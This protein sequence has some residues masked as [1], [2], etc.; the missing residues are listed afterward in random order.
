MCIRINR[1]ILSST[2]I[3]FLSAA[4]YF[5]FSIAYS[6][7]TRLYACALANDDPAAFMGGSSIGAGLWQS[8]DTGRTWKQLGWKHVKCYS[9]DVVHKSNGKIIYQAC[10]NGVLKSVDAG[11]TWKMLTDWRITEVLDIAVDQKAPNNIYI[12]TP[13]AIWKSDDAGENWYEANTDIPS[14]I[15]ASRIHIGED[16]LHIIATTEKGI[17]ESHDGSINWKIT[18]KMFLSEAEVEASH[19]RDVPKNIHSVELIGADLFIGSL[20]G[21]VWRKNGISSQ[22]TPERVGLDQLQ[23]WRL[24]AVE[25]K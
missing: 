9:V 2:F 16:H 25:I 20:S 18:N 7:H 10:G 1:R 21:G 23:I 12:A 8:D 6:Q 11:S 15:F 3:I 13:L 14:P 22:Q 17:Y 24:K 5:P 4:F 19:L